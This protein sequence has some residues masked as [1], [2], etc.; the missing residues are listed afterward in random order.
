M[1][2]DGNGGVKSR[3]DGDY[4]HVIVLLHGI[5]TR[6]FWFDVAV[7]ILG[8][9]DR[10]EVRPLGYG[11]Y[12]LFRFLFPFGRGGPQR[13]ILAK[14]RNIKEEYRRRGDRIKLS[15]IAH[16]F[17]TYTIVSILMNED[18]LDLENLILCGSV[19]PVDSRLG[20][21]ARKIQNVRLNDVGAKDIW[22]V[23]AK[24]SSFG[25]GESGTFGF[26]GDVFVDRF[27]NLSH[28]DFFTEEFI[29][30]FWLPIFTGNHVEPSGYIR[31]TKRDSR[32]PMIL[33]MLPR[34]FV[35]LLAVVLSIYPISMFAIP[36]AAMFICER[37]E[38]SAS[39][40]QSDD[41]LLKYLYPDGL[42]GQRNA[43]AT[44][45]IISFMMSQGLNRT[46][47]PLFLYSQQYA[48]QRAQLVRQLGL[49]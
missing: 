31:E 20:S 46:D 8:G 38:L 9:V 7:P 45:L 30:K 6:A 21:I 15:V 17:G 42:N 47:L 27:H 2:I 39:F 24:I 25:Y 3:V 48:A 37:F 34:A 35:P 11:Y 32:L 41:A 5:R 18:D 40:C 1:L 4:T 28:S 10:V 22:P 16:S 19:L 12:N 14:I 26:L 33:S 49:R 23:L 44:E 13:T 43:E 29:R 36:S